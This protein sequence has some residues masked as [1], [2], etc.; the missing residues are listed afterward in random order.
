MKYLFILMLLAPKPV[1][2]EGVAA[3]VGKKIILVSEIKEKLA[4]Q[5]NQ[6]CSIADK[7][8]QKSTIDALWKSALEE[9]I[10][11]VLMQI[12]GQSHNI[13][14][15]SEQIDRA[16]RLILQQNKFTSVEQLKAKL[17]EKNYPFLLWRKDVKRH[18][19]MTE[20]ASNLVYTKVHIDDEAVKSFYRQKVREA[21]AEAKVKVMEI[22]IPS[23]RYIKL[24][25]QIKKDLSSGNDFSI[26]M[27]KYKK[28]GFV[29]AVREN[30]S[31]GY[32]P[33]VVDQLLFKT[34]SLKAG[35]IAGPVLTEESA[36]IIK[37]IEKNESG[38]VSFKN[39]KAKLK[40]ELTARMKRKKM[41][42]WVKSLRT[43]HLVDIRISSP[44]VS[45]ICK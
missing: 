18:L 40:R 3:V 4:L 10:S 17:A 37:I 12:E 14:I 1:L 25:E 8:A 16:I 38:F 19:L 41:N 27:E 26:I 20:L 9:E 6:I 45:L 43:K 24:K 31:P 35:S 2:V 39:V 22:R 29:A 28:L 23:S 5:K 13:Y 21:N 30:V 34:K 36:Y 7:K 42:E 32:F 15:G 33:P 11:Q 44:P